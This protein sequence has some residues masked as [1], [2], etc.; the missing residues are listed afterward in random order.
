MAGNNLNLYKKEKRRES[1]SRIR[2]ALFINEYIYCKYFHIYHEAAE[3]YNNI[4][5]LYPRKP[6]LRRTDEFRVW[7][8]NIA[9]GQSIDI[10]EKP[11]QKQRQYVHPV[12]ENIPIPQYVDPTASLVVM[13]DLGNENS[14]PEISRTETESPP[15]ALESPR[16]E[17]ESPPPA[18]ESPRTESTYQKVMQLRIPLLTTYPK[19]PK[20]TN[21][22][23]Q[24]PVE[25][26]ETV[27]D[28]V[29][30]ESTD[31]LH[32]SL[33]DEIS[34]EIIDKIISELRQEPELMDV[35]TE[36]EQQIEIEEA[37][38]DIDIPDLCDPLE[39]E[40]ENILW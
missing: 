10:C 36:I 1:R 25:T 31:I 9:R 37:G 4:N 32:P 27:T 20:V 24:T 21:E 13:P 30:Q 7:K 18:P 15:P 34:P 39:N 12:H 22:A 33:M 8:T 23:L 40:L 2:E 5:E 17:T 11:N 28:E 14:P 16:T 6:D 26:L 3:L 38:L 35:V 19:D 29:I